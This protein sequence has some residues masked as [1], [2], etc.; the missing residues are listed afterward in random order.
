MVVPLFLCV[1]EA[2]RTRQSN[3]DRNR[4]HHFLAV[5]PLVSLGIG[6]WDAMRGLSPLDADAVR[7][8]RDSQ[9]WFD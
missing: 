7:N 2:A 5:L 8:R 9:R 4:D 6:L 3:A 1:T